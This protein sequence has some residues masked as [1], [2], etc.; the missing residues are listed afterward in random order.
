M[1]FVERSPLRLLSKFTVANGETSLG[2]FSE[3]PYPAAVEK[4]CPARAVRRHAV[5]NE[6]DRLGSNVVDMRVF[7]NISVNAHHILVAYR[8]KPASTTPCE[9]CCCTLVKC[10]EREAMSQTLECRLNSYTKI[11]APLSQGQAAQKET[12]FL[13]VNIFYSFCLVRDSI[14]ESAGR[15]VLRADA[16]RPK[17]HSNPEA[18]HLP[19][20]SPYSGFRS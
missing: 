1:V 9:S 19:R 11:L 2:F 14:A 3:K 4:R 13:F 7:R 10:G 15:E 6:D 17:Y 20:L 12:A 8:I 16:A 5:K 18:Y